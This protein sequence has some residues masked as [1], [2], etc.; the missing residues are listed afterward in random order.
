M[1]YEQ[2]NEVMGGGG[3]FGGA[4]MMAILFA[5]VVFWLI[6]ERRDGHRGG[7]YG[8]VQ[9]G[10]NHGGCNPVVSGMRPVFCDESNYEQD[11]YICGKFDK[12]YEAIR[13][14]GE[15]T[16]SLIENNFVKELERKIAERDLTIA[17]Q[18]NEAFTGGLFGKL[19]HRLDRMECEMLKRPPTWGHAVTP[20][21]GSIELGCGGVRRGSCDGFGAA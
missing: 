9:N 13:Q 20:C 11:K 6:F 17:T 21:A 19:D 2:R 4:G 1:T 5:L 7:G 3:L 14:E 12:E 8:D 10:Y 18:C 16:R 15:K